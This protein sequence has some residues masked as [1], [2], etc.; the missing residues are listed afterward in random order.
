LGSLLILKKEY[1]LTMRGAV[2]VQH[3]EGHSEF[4]LFEED[5]RKQEAYFKTTMGKKAVKYMLANTLKKMGYR[6]G[7]GIKLKIVYE[8]ES[9]EEIQT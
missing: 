3:I 2:K 5:A 1:K 4:Y 9:N 8:D 7:S 6:A